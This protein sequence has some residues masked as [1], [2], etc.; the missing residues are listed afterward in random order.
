ML[1]KTCS[2]CIV[3]FSAQALEAMD[4][5]KF[6]LIKNTK[7]LTSQ[8]IYAPHE[9]KCNCGGK[10]V[11]ELNFRFNAIGTSFSLAHCLCRNQPRTFNESEAKSTVFD[12]RTWQKKQN[13]IVPLDLHQQ[14]RLLSAQYI[15]SNLFGTYISNEPDITK[16]N[17]QTSR[18][19]DNGLPLFFD[20]MLYANK[21]TSSLVTTSNGKKL[22]LCFM[23]DYTTHI[24]KFRN[25][26]K[27]ST[28]YGIQPE[29]YVKK[30]SLSIFEITQDDT[31]KEFNKKYISTLGSYKHLDHKRLYLN[32]FQNHFNE[33]QIICGAY[34]GQ[35]LDSYIFEVAS[36]PEH[37]I[38][39]LKK[40]VCDNSLSDVF[41][42]TAS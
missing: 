6:V 19:E 25:K 9:K 3:L 5:P 10:N 30:G 14:K 8:E 2:L 4:T 29:E 23:E 42:Y 26:R 16:N 22:L 24:E 34:D 40:R 36:L 15:H 31:T 18:L 1:R 11:C 32:V 41:I 39:M 35:F 7:K 33:I 13:E 20:T 17:L 37:Y 21:Q 27:N 38:W 28:L 12:T